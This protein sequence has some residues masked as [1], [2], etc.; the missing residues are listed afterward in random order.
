MK[1]KVSDY[2]SAIRLDLINPR[3]IVN[4]GANLYAYTV[5]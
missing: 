3:N 4:C 1:F 2:V 5:F